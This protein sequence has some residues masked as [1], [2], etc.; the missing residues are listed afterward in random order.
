MSDATTQATNLITTPGIEGFVPGVYR[1][2]K[3]IATIG[4]GT[5]LVVQ[6][7]GTWTPLAFGQVTA[8]LQGT[9]IT[10]T[11][12]QYNDTL[13]PSLAA[14]AAVLNSNAKSPATSQ[15]V[16]DNNQIPSD[17]KGATGV[18]FD[19]TAAGYTAVV[20]TS[21]QQTLSVSSAQ[22]TTIVTNWLTNP[23]PAL[24]N[25]TA[26]QYLV[27]IVYNNILNSDY[28]GMDSERVND[29]ETPA[30]S[31]LSSSVFMRHSSFLAD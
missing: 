31:S 17:L 10:L 3:G 22:A 1:D 12:Q 19:G 15:N 23:N 28:P 14:N 26:Q 21:V 9:G 29:F 13:L 2:L 20:P 16:S 11:Q 5:A 30:G 4:Y 7:G 6:S 25:G 18:T 8:L 27:N 24:G